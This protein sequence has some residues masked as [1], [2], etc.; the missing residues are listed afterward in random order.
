MNND[1]ILSC[2]ERNYLILKF[3]DVNALESMNKGVWYFRHP[4][5]Y[6]YDAIKNGNTTRGDKYE[7][8][9]S[10]SVCGGLSVFNLIKN[11]KTRGIWPYTVKLY[12]SDDERDSM[13]FISFYSLEILDDWNL[14]NIDNRMKDFGDYVAIVQYNNLYRELK[15]RY[16]IQ[17]IQVQYLD[18]TYC[19][20]MGDGHKN[21]KYSYQKERRLIIKSESFL[22]K[23]REND[24]LKVIQKKYFELRKIMDDSCKPNG[25]R[26]E[27]EK[28][29]EEL[30]VREAEIRKD[31]YSE[32]KTRCG[33]LS[34]IIPVVE[35]FK[36]KTI[37]D[38]IKFI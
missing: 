2:E 19:G 29:M 4:D 10:R 36:M 9:I 26:I 22:S 27:A 30:M 8:K 6:V 13:R 3:S 35:L 32:V 34:K 12:K 11:K 18:E 20:D 1:Y 28:K 16:R 5:Y 21:R 38:L 17:N 31:F 15:N 14:D 37:N 33:L 7:E 25:E 23:I 24:E